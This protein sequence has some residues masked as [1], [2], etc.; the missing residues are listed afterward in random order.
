[1]LWP[2][3]AVALV[4]ALLTAAATPWVLRTLPEPDDAEAEDKPPYASLATGRFVAVVALA[5]L[6]ASLLATL[7]LPWQHWLAW[8]SL[9]TVGVLACSI[10]ARTT[11]LPLPLARVGWVVAGAGALLV[12]ASSG[13][14]TPLLASALGAVALGGLFHLL[15]RFTGAFGYGDVR[16]AATIGAVTALD[17][18]SLVGWSL[19][20]GTAAGA[21]VGIVHRLAGR[22]GGFPYGPGLLAGPLLAVAVRL[23]LG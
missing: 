5:S 20:L 17:S 16:L 18:S 11:W 14:W 19:V 22:R 15:W 12:A 13:S 10:D 3:P 23:A 7:A 1:M 21:L 4:G 9:S 8:A 2:A 6:G